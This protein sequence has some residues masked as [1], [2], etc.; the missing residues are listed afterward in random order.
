MENQKLNDVQLKKLATG[1]TTILSE[2]Q[3]GSGSYYFP[4]IYTLILSN[5]A[6]YA[7][8]IGKGNCPKIFLGSVIIGAALSKVM[9]VLVFGDKKL[10]ELA[11]SDIHSLQSAGIY[12][13]LA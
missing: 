7:H 12:N 4:I 6:I 2:Q 1:S 13:R 5:S 3:V 8:R 11:K 10:N 9:S